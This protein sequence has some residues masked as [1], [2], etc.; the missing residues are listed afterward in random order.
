VSSLTILATESLQGF[1]GSPQKRGGEYLKERLGLSQEFKGTT[2]QPAK[3][4]VF[5]QW[6]GFVE[7]HRLADGWLISGTPTVSA[8]LGRGMCRR[9]AVRK[10]G[11]ADA[12]RIAVKQ[13]DII[14][15][16]S[17][18]D[19]L[20]VALDRMAQMSFSLDVLLP[21]LEVRREGP[22]DV[23]VQ[24]RNKAGES[25]GVIL[26]VRDNIAVLLK[27]SFPG[28]AESIDDEI[29]KAPQLDK[30]Q[31]EAMLPLPVVSDVMLD[32]SGND[33]QYGRLYVTLSGVP[34]T[35]ALAIEGVQQSGGG[36]AFIRKEGRMEFNRVRERETRGQKYGIVVYDRES[37]LSRW[38]LGEI[39]EGNRSGVE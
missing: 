39:P 34:Q 28:L 29:Q 27:D 10:P 11:K 14:V 6:R 22:G 13:L 36:G 2:S 4:Q 19:A 30:V 31:Y 33:P 12:Q 32:M 1:G 16:V 24:G 17:N 35:A 38:V 5:R 3:P 15:G 23:A 7:D 37:L 18:E 26:F 21:R 8:I 25:M 20:E 9:Y